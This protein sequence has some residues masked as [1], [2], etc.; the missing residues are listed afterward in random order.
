MKKIIC[1]VLCALFLVTSFGCSVKRVK[2]A[3]YGGSDKY[4]ITQNMYKYWL[5]YYKTRFYVI[6]QQYG[7]ISESTYTEDFWAQIIEGDETYGDRV[8]NHVN[9]L[10]NDM[11]VSAALYDEFKL[12]S[13]TNTKKTLENTVQSFV[14]SDI[15]AAGSRADLNK[16]LGQF[17]LNI[18]E[19][20]K[21]Y[22]FEAKE[23]IVEDHLFGEKG[24]EPVTDAER[25]EYYQNT[26][27]RIKYVLLDPYK[28]QVTDENGYPVMDTSTGYYKTVDLTEEE[29]AEV[30]SLA[31]SIRANAA[32]GADFEALIAE[33]NQ[34]SAMNTYIDG[35]F[36][37]ADDA[38]DVTFLSDVISMKVGEVKISES[39]YGLLIIKKYPLEKGLWQNSISASFFTDLDSDITEIKKDK[40]FS[41]YY[42]NVSK[43]GGFPST[44]KLADLPFLQTALTSAE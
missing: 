1:T 4:V 2:Y 17:G 33:Y 13:D 24:K 15:K 27:H 8:F 28:K 44:L 20:K 16:Q 12:G 26:Y 37:K 39:P 38:Y 9:T 30:R 14:D 40:K 35:Y 19:L 25:E 18:D 11:L 5:A 29:Q 10:I 7:I 21:I 3:S 42:Q 23:L 43:D 22:E 31:E 34:D 32:A 6:M 36:F 41:A